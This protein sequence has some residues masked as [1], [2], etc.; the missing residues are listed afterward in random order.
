M[1]TVKLVKTIGG[2]FYI[3]YNDNE[4]NTDTEMIMTSVRNLAMQMTAHGPSVAAMPLV[5]FA[6]KSPDT[7]TIKFDN[8]VCQ[9]DEMNINK[10]LLAGYKSEIS[11]IITPAKPDVIV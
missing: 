9:V 6:N 7:I 2:E 5:P 1:E 8:I 10:D 3:G 11:G 4:K